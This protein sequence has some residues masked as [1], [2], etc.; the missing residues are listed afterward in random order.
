MGTASAETAKGWAGMTRH[1]GRGWHGKLLAA[2]LGVT[3]LAAATSVWTA[4]ADTA[5]GR[6]PQVRV[7]A[8]E[9][10]AVAADIAH[11]SVDCARGVN[12]TIDDG[13]DPTWTPQVLRSHVAAEFV[14][15]RLGR[16]TAGAGPSSPGRGEPSPDCDGT[17]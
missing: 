4:Q 13:P 15:H 5:G 9:I 14:I 7:A 12:I 11:A 2:A 10:R 6:Q 16:G 1:K 8:P 3:A 17:A